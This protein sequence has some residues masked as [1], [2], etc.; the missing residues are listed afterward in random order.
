M[1]FALMSLHL[2][3]VVLNWTPIVSVRGNL[4]FFSCLD[5]SWIIWCFCLMIFFYLGG[6]SFAVSS[7]ALMRFAYLSVMV[8]LS[9]H[10]CSNF[11]LI[12]M[13]YRSFRSLLLS[14]D[15]QQNILFSWAAMNK[16]FIYARPCVNKDFFS[17]WRVQLCFSSLFLSTK[18]PKFDGNDKKLF[19]IFG[20]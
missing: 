6:T 20:I 10:R 15:H 4:Q 3:S 19:S 16:I 17:W 1:Q 7:I 9:V 2:F 11:F 5:P 13:V 8:S 18:Y 14:K 12:V